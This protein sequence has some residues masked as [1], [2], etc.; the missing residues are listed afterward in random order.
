MTT[1]EAL[2]PASAEEALH[3]Y[4]FYYFLQ[5]THYK[6]FSPQTQDSYRVKKKKDMKNSGANRTDALRKLSCP[7]FYLEAK[8]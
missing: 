6:R 2:P 8:S 3:I 1:G 4:C 7:D 5:R